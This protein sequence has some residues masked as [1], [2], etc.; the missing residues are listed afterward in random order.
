MA[1]SLREYGYRT[2]EPREYRIKCMRH[3]L[4]EN[5]I[6]KFTEHCLHV[7]QFQ[8]IVLDD[9]LSFNLELSRNERI[10][11]FEMKRRHGAFEE[12]Q[13]AKEEIEK[14]KNERDT[15]KRKYDEIET[16]RVLYDNML[17]YAR[18]MRETVLELEEKVSDLNK[19]VIRLSEAG[20]KR[21]HGEG[22]YKKA[23][24]Y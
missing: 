2:D 10:D 24:K 14:V 3:C 17:K 1:L 13:K 5:D 20:E 19:D 21:V 22:Y 11:I 23:K 4:D 9:F 18:S 6:N 15:L 16:Y 8:E 7:G 12:R